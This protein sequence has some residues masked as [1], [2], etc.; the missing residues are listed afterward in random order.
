MGDGEKSLNV[1]N[2]YLVGNS[3]LEDFL[4]S[5]LLYFFKN[6]SNFIIYIAGKI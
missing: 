3:N 2:N 1:N 4:L 5:V 6:S